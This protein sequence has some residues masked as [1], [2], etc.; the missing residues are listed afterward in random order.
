MQ[1]IILC[2]LL[3]AT[4][5]TLNAQNVV[6]DANAQVR[7]VGTF[8]KIDIS[9]AINL[10]LSQGSTQGVAVSSTDPDA[11]GKIKT[12]VRNGVLKIFVQNG[13]WNGWNWSNK[14][15]KAYIT[16][17]TLE[18]LNVSGACNVEITDPVKVGDLKLELSGAS[19]LYGSIKGNNIKFE[20]SG[21][22]NAKANFTAAS[23]DL[24]QTGASN[25]KGTINSGKTSLDMSGASVTDVNGTA[26]DLIV[27]AS[28]ASNFKGGD[29]TAENCRIEAT[30]ASSAS[31]NVNKAIQATASGGSSIR[32]SGAANITNLDVSGGSTVKKKS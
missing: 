13:A 6:R 18:S 4:G 27:D 23:F 8:T 21:A 20:L 10:Y 3:V 29:L 1:K 14:H 5:F 11:I 28:G 12:E 32:Y 30:G 31:I 22:S 17:T 7:N 25:F 16:F 2:L 26:T 15:L 9:S 24:S 19:N